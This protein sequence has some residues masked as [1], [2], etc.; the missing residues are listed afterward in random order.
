MTQSMSKLSILTIGAGAIGSYVSGRL[1]ASGNEVTFLEKAEVAPVLA[2]KGLTI[3]RENQMVR[4]ESIEVT[5]SLHQALATKTY[6]L[7]LVAIKAYDT[8]TLIK[9][10]LPYKDQLPPILS[11]QNGVENEALFRSAFGDNHVIAGTVTS[12][13]AWKQI[14]EIT[15]EKERGIGIAIECELARHL[16]N[17]LQQAGF[18]VKNYTRPEDMK[19]SKLITNQLV[20]ASCA[21]LDMPPVAVLSHPASFRLEMLQIRE[22]LRVMEAYGIKVVDLPATPVRFLVWAIR[23]LPFWISQPLFIY[24]IGK[25][26]GKKMPSLYLDFVAGRQQ[27]EVDALNGAVVR[28]GEQAS[29]STPVNRFLTQTL[30]DLIQGKIPRSTYEHSPHNLLQNCLL[31]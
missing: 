15:I 30:L 14:G 18:N 28:F 12:A 23:V 25:G 27:S 21:I 22:T 1:L 7:I 10:L 29:L 20:N 11:L 16:S 17:A 6:D 3:H 31:Q 2:Q 19:W 26:R 5:S 8:P 24:F 4:I 13:I 9:T